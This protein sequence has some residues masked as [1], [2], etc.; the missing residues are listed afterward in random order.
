M[1]GGQQVYLDPDGSLRFTASHSAAI[2]PGSISCPLKSEIFNS[3]LSEVL[4]S[5]FG[6][7]T[8]MAC[9]MINSTRVP[10][11]WQVYANIPNATVP[12]LHAN[13]SSCLAFEAIGV[14]VDLGDSPAAYGYV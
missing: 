1:A 5:G 11:Q 12:L 6:A 8:F 2:A 4:V 13:S 7:T 3:E 9:P 14:K 10:E